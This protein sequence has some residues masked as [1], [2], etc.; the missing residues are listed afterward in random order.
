[1]CA[2]SYRVDTLYPMG[3]ELQIILACAGVLS[4]AAWLW[5]TQ[6]GEDRQ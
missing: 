6:K 5:T 2:W 3:R 4:C 1:L